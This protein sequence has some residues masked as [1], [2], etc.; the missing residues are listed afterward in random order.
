MMIRSHIWKNTPSIFC[1]Q[2]RNIRATNSYRP[3]TDY[4]C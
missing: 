3:S 1:I 4:S 2:W